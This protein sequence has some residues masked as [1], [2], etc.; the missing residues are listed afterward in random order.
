MEGNAIACMLDSKEEKENTV[1][2]RENRKARRK[3]RTR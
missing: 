1:R 2:E 3:S